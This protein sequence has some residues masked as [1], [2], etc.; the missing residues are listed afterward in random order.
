MKTGIVFL[1][2]TLLVTLVAAPTICC[3]GKDGGNVSG[4]GIQIIFHRN[5]EE[6][7]IDPQLPGFRK[8]ARACE[9]LF[10]TSDDVLRLIVTGETISSIRN[11]ERAVEIRYRESRDFIM[12]LN[13]S[14]LRPSRLLIPLS[15]EFGGEQGDA[16]ATI[17]HGHPDYSAGPVTNSGGSGPVKRI[18][19]ELDLW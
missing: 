1:L 16:P 18:L 11:G 9:E 15:G 14:V 17:F 13:G 7:T 6:K 19:R 3:D 4:N 10:T 2:F 5:G 12:D 8:L